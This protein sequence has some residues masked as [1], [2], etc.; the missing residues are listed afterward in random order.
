VT[1]RV[2]RVPALAA[3]LALLAAPAAADAQDP[4]PAGKL[5]TE[6]ATP[7]ERLAKKVSIDRFEGKFKEAVQ[8]LGDKFDLPV[9]IDPG[10]DKSQEGG[11]MVEDRPVRLP[12]MANVRLDTVLKV[13]GEQVNGT[14]LVY[15]DYVK[16]T[17]SAFALYESGVIRQH[18]PGEVEE[19]PFLP[20]LE[21]EKSKPLIKRAL[22]NLSFKNAP[23]GRVLD[24]IADSTGATVV[25]SPLVGEKATLPL[26]ARFANTPVDAAVRTLCEMADLGVIEDANVLVVTTRERAADRARQEEAR[27]QARQ[28]ALAAAGGP[29][30]F[31]GLGGLGGGLV[32]GGGTGLAGG[33][34]AVPPDLAAE[35]ARLKEQNEQLKKQLD[36]IQ[37]LLK[38]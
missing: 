37:K 17:G 16:L 8:F 25:L 30:G 21:L 14:F 34:A 10:L 3:A 20:A 35:L 29:G 36:E 11:E 15:P 13:L 28:A 19:V 33:P 26:T 5:T 2:R 38:K 22:V 4:K 24:E 32:G 9:V 31:V 1:A 23:L 27:R 12:K 6:K 7:A 18:E